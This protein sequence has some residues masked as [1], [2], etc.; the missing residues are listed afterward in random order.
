MIQMKH[1][2]AYELIC[3]LMYL[4]GFPAIL[5]CEGFLAF[6]RRGP[7]ELRVAAVK[8]AFSFDADFPSGFTSDF[9]NVTMLFQEGDTLS[10]R[11]HVP[12]DNVIVLAEPEYL[13][14]LVREFMRERKANFGSDPP[15]KVGSRV[16][17]ENIGD[18]DETAAP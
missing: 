5:H 2:Q 14:C 3:L 15:I 4:V 16:T 6:I 12:S 7:K 9:V 11:Y 8:P 18:D 13:K 1:T 10:V 17:P